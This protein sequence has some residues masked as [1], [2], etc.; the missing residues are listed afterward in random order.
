VLE[1]LG[2]V[3]R[4]SRHNCHGGLYEHRACQA[5]G[6]L[7]APFLLFDRRRLPSHIVA[8]RRAQMLSRMAAFSD[9]TPP[10]GLGF[11]S[12]R[13]QPITSRRLGCGLRRT[14]SVRA[15]A[16]IPSHT[17]CKEEALLQECLFGPNAS[18]SC[19]RRTS[20]RLKRKT[21]PPSAQFSAQM[22][23]P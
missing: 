23:P 6:P 17:V 9:H 22:F 13:A 2:A 20:G 8:G 16:P 11:Y 12:N 4:A 19:V 7:E 10:G 21:A 18:V 5:S 3:W 15:G 14:I 1:F